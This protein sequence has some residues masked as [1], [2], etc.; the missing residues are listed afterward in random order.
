MKL[1]IIRLKN[2][3][4]FDDLTINLGDTPKKIIALVGPNGCG[5]SS[6]FDAF[7]EILKDYKGASQN[8]HA[9]YFSKLCYSI[10][11]DKKAENYNKNESIT[12]TKEDGT[13][14]FDK[15]KLLY[16]NRH[17]DLLRN[18]IVDSPASYSF[19]AESCTKVLFFF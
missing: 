14:S 16:Q 13:N 2:F 9:S 15:K 5:K 3:K 12:I 7:E 10:L 6:V 19:R 8:E 1:K 17:I 4:R 11:P 18:Q